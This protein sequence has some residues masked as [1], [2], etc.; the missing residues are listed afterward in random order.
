M[1]PTLQLPPEAARLWAWPA[2]LDR[3]ESDYREAIAAR[4]VKMTA[5]A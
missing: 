3:M 4:Q 5:P 2:L 1:V